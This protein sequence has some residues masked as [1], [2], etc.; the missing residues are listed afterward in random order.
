MLEKVLRV[1]QLFDLYGDLLTERQK[2]F[3]RL[4]YEEDFSLG[5]IAIAFNISRQAVYD[6]LRRS[7]TL[8]EE[9]EDKL[10]LLQRQQSWSKA[11]NQLSMLLERLQERV[12]GDQEALA[13][14][15][16]IK[17]LVGPFQ[18]NRGKGG[19]KC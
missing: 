6:T 17:G 15:E 16:E 19:E 12:A 11:I 18:D 10:G 13:L 1:V 7:E 8:L 9:W 2:K 3:I 4:Y 5:E 14:I